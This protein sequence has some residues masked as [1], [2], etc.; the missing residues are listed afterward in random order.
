MATAFTPALAATAY[1]AIGGLRPIAGSDPVPEPDPP[2]AVA[3]TPAAV[4]APTAS[5]PLSRPAG[6]GPLIV[7]PPPPPPLPDSEPV[8]IKRVSTS[9]TAVAITFDACATKTHTSGFDRGIFDVLKRESIPATIFVSGRWVEAHPGEMA[10]LVAN[11]LIEFGDHSYDHPHMRALTPA[12]IAGEIDQT[13]AALARYGKRSVAFRP[14]FGEW[15]RRLLT[16]VHGKEL[17]SVLWDVVSG[18]P[19]AR[20]TAPGMIRT[21]LRGTRPGSIVVFH[22]NG[23]GTKTAAALPA[24][25]HGLRARGLVLVHLSQLLAQSPLPLPPPR[26]ST[27]PP[28]L[29]PPLLVEPGP[30]DRRTGAAGTPGVRYRVVR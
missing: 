11:P 12:Q 22:I 16:V 17:P 4:T 5:V 30:P 26:P 24:I 7:L 9:E 23:R 20:T 3:A 1:L 14:P 21:V 6:E 13:E 19:S 15:N 8:L 10:E 2:P 25:V 29:A 27:E 18:D 28:P